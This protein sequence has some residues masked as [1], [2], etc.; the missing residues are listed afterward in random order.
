[1]AWVNICMKSDSSASIMFL[2]GKWV[3]LFQ[4]PDGI[5]SVDNWNISLCWNTVLRDQKCFPF[6]SA[7]YSVYVSLAAQNSASRVL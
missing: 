6:P 7:V 2:Y 1:M 3:D 5:V 4:K